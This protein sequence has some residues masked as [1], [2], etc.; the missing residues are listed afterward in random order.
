MQNEIWNQFGIQNYNGNVLSVYSVLPAIEISLF[1]PRFP[2]ED[3]NNPIPK[4]PGPLQDCS[5]YE[6]RP[7]ARWMQ[8]LPRS[9]G[10]PA[11]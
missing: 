8:C 7:T 9:L 5:T 4:S 6:S 1:E 3:G 10:F 11:R 2:Q